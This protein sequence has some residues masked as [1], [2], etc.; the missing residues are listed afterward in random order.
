MLK[1]LLY[2][3]FIS[4]FRAYRAGISNSN[5]LAG[6]RFVVLTKKYIARAAFNEL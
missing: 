2:F 1:K 3:Q 4:Q 5:P 6:C